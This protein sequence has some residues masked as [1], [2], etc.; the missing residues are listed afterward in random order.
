[1]TTGIKAS[2]PFI[3]V[4]DISGSPLKDGY[5]K[6]Y[7][8]GTTTATQAYSDVTLN[9][10]IGTEVGLDSYGNASFYVSPLLNYKFQYYDVDDNLIRTDDNITGMYNP[11]TAD[12]T[13]ELPPRFIDEKLVLSYTTSDVVTIKTGICIDSLNSYRMINAS[14]FLCDLT[15][16]WQAA[17]GLGSFPSALTLSLT[18]FYHVFLLYNPTSRAIS[19]GFDT[20][21]SATNL[22]ADSTATGYTVYRRIGT[23]YRNASG[24][25]EPFDMVGDTTYFRT[26]VTSVSSTSNPGTTAMSKTVAAP[27]GIASIEAMVKL[28][29]TETA[30]TETDV[31]LGKSGWTITSANTVLRVDN[32][33]AFVDCTVPAN[34]SAQI[35]IQF[36]SSSASLSYT[37]YTVGWKEL[38]GK[39]L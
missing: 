2:N 22:L 9:T 26:P 37:L 24:N 29:V 4:D 6:L 23:V 7:L 28:L 16:D 31:Y 8:A 20:S 19:A 39:E 18:T 35:R 5:I 13:A 27:T 36:S 1:M 14:D 38:R 10:S 32:N 33:S 12:Y 15:V 34:S 25:I 3:H 30:S 17:S 11:L 21:L